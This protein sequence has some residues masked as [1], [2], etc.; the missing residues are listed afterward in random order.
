MNKNSSLKQKFK[1]KEVLNLSMK[2]R[3]MQK[4]SFNSLAGREKE[5]CWIF[6]SS[7]GRNMKQQMIKCVL[8]K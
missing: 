3:E 6:M 4:I 5:Q 1:F 7:P 2:L 8:K